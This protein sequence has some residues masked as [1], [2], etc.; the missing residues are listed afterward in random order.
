[1]QR[2]H[3]RQVL[4]NGITVLVVEN[5][6]ADIVA[7]RCFL[8]GGTSL[9]LPP[10]I[11]ISH[12]VAALITKGT[13]NFSSQ[14]IA[15]QVESIGA[16]LGTEAAVDYFLLSFKTISSDFAEI[17]HLA[18]EILRSPTFPDS[19]LELERRLT[20]QAIAAQQERPFSVAYEQLQ[21]LIYGAH[22][23][24]FPGLGKA[25]TI[26]SISQADL[27]E[28]HQTQFRPDRMVVSIAGRID[29][30]SAIVQIEKAFGDW[31]IPDRSFP[32][33]DMKAQFNP[34]VVSTAQDTQQAIV[35]L[36]YPA[37]AVT[38][39]DYAALKLIATYL[40]NGLSSRLFVELREKQGLAYEV[41]AFYPTRLHTSQFVAYMGT[42]PHNTQSALDGLRSECDRLR[43]APLEPEE[44]ETAKSK[45]LGQ[46][47]LG[48]QTNSQIAQIFG[49]Y[50]TLGLGLDFD[51]KFTTLVE[52]VT[53]EDLQRAANTY[54]STPAISLVGPASALEI[55]S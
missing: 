22:P 48:K 55:K 21:P 5:P 9:E 19:E 8:R 44:I 33:I 37:P 29:P 25:D 10:T 51:P 15:E 28:F 13:V 49:W 17:L 34:Q 20:L 52:A 53:V 41:S 26:S 31:Q 14:E 40:G 18:A 1:M 38:S 42:A 46:Y 2:Q 39:T 54:L 24:G 3:H 6:T 7:T 11:G 47:A 4:D 23:Y 43:H 35:M 12:L 30:V 45:L 36:G 32:I 16:S 50:E 27:V